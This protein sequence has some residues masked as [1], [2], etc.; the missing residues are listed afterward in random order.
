VS[1][2]VEWMNSLSAGVGGVIGIAAGVVI[3]VTLQIV[4][5]RLCDAFE[6]WRY[7]RMF[8]NWCPCGRKDG[9]HES[10]CLWVVRLK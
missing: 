1:A 8:R 10:W 6:S 2:F 4:V 9:T 3:M 7:R 5:P